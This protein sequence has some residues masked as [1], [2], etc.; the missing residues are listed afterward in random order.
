MMGGAGEMGQEQPCLVFDSVIHGVSNIWVHF[1]LWISC[2]RL[3]N[4][5]RFEWELNQPEIVDPLHR[6]MIVL[7][8]FVYKGLFI[9]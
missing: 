8:V 9:D 2:M 5:T 7:G 4:M 3:V 6:H 1:I